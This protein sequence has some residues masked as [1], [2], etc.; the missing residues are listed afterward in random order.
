MI[1]TS[2]AVEIL[3]KTTHVPEPQIRGMA[4][5][6]IDEGF[7]PKSRG[8]RV[9]EMDVE[10]F[11]LL[12]IAVHVTTPKK[13][14]CE[15]AQSYFD[16]EGYYPGAAPFRTAG[17]HIAAALR[18]YIENGETA[19]AHGLWGSISVMVMLAHP[20]VTVTSLREVAKTEYGRRSTDEKPK[21]YVEF[22]AGTFARIAQLWHLPAAPGGGEGE[23]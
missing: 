7:L 20:Y 17:K 8:R 19:V 9:A 23:K 1:S 18:A 14:A 10:Q 6:L 12:L 3:K 21:T 22:P 5:R 2:R 4:R 15:I 13:G 11:A 16:L